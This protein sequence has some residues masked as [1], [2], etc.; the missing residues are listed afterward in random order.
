MYKNLMVAI[1][2]SGLVGFVLAVEKPTSLQDSCVTSECHTN[3]KEKAHLHG[4][5][6]LD[7]CKACHKPV[8]PAQ[9]S[10]KLLHAINDLC[11]SCHLEIAT[12]KNVHEP[13]KSGNCL[14]CHDPHS[15]DNKFFLHRTTVAEQCAECHEYSLRKGRS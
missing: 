4:P 5:V 2:F 7:D 6:E 10:W 14:D 1:L 13:L 12:M 3:Y 15:S 9:H 8:D 11:Q